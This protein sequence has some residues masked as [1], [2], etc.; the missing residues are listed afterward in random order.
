M[1]LTLFLPRTASTS[2]LEVQTLLKFLAAF[3]NAMNPESASSHTWVNLRLSRQAISLI[4]S[5]SFLFRRMT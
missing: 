2:G 4:L 3:V 5:T 1:D